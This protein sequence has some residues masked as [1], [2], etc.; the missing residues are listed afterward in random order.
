[1]LITIHQPENLPW[2]GFFHKM[3]LCDK[4]VVLDSVQFTKNNVQNRNK[5]FSEKNDYSWVSVPVSIK[6]H[7]S[8][9]LANT[10]ISSENNPKWKMSYWGKI[11]SAYKSHPYFKIY[12]EELKDIIYKDEPYLVN[13]NMNLIN[14]F[15]D[16][17]DITTQIF[18]SSGLPVAGK[19]SDLLLS[20][21]EHLGATTYLSGPSGKN[22]L[23][24]NIFQEKNIQIDYHQFEYPKYPARKYVKYLSTI[25]LLMNCGPESKKYLLG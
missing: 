14:F 25:D 5:I 2:L 4:Y 19:R 6:G 9:V 20:I 23:D 1:M 17:L 15:R 18:R 12:H 7:T 21:C 10:K 24:K 3:A 8:S 22:Y 13:F 16:K 11:E